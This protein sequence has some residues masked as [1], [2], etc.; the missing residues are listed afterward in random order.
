MIEHDFLSD[1]PA[2]RRLPAFFA[3]PAVR[4]AFKRLHNQHNIDS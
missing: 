2:P 3:T 4:V 1:D